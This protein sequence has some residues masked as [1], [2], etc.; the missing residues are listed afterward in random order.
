M[1][2]RTSAMTLNFGNGSNIYG[3]FTLGSGVT[4]TGAQNLSFSGTGTQTLTT[5]GKTISF[6]VLVNKPINGSSLELGDALSTSIDSLI[7][8]HMKEIFVIGKDFRKGDK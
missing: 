5:I 4:T 3:S 1:S 8:G 2:S 7:A 6:S